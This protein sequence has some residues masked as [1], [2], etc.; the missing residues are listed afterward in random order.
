MVSTTCIEFPAEGI[1]RISYNCL[2]LPEDKHRRIYWFRVAMIQTVTLWSKSQD[3]EFK[4][5]LLFLFLV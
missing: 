1:R 2:G 4:Y 3:F 5:Y